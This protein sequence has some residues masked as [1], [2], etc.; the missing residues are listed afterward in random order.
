MNCTLFVVHF[1]YEHTGF[2]VGAIDPVKCIFYGVKMR[3]TP[4][5]SV[6]IKNYMPFFLHI[7]NDMPEFWHIKIYIIQNIKTKKKSTANPFRESAVLFGTICVENG[8]FACKQWGGGS[9]LTIRR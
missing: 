6:Y 2:N 8:G 5:I 7:K 1:A 9:A 3:K 4:Y